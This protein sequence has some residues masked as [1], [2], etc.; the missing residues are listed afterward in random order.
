MNQPTATKQS[1]QTETP[2]N[3][4][5]RLPVNRYVLFCI[6]AGLGVF[7]D[8]F[9]KTYFFDSYHEPE[10]PLNQVDWWINGV[11][12]I[13][14]SFNGGALF[15]MFQGGSFWLAGLSFIA[16]GGIV[17][18]LFWFQMAQSRWMT[19]ALGLITGG[20][21]GNLYDRMGFGYVARYGEQHVYHVR[22]WI[23]FRLQGVP[24]CDPWPNFNIA[25]S[26]LVT[27]AIMLFI[28]A[29]IFP[30]PTASNVPASDD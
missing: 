15:G 13:Q 20:I 1:P 5:G 9:S 27:G 12:G 17:V 4:G 7:A 19:V 29:L 8:L 14:T 10:E 11:L 22:D 21:L 24:F 16:L 28:F 3:E 6:L 2:N 30:D 18:W 25:D 26:L 23:H